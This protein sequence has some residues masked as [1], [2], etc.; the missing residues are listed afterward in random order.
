M[1]N[2]LDIKEIWLAVLKKLETDIGLGE[3]EMWMRP[4]K[5]LSIED[6]TLKLEVPDSMICDT[7]K[8]RYEEKIKTVVASLVGRQLK[9]NYF[10][11]VASAL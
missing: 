11:S 8:D 5:P 1:D 2:L 3:V 6:E 9:I 10:L 7:V 4:I